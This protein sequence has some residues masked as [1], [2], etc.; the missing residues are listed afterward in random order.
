[1]YPHLHCCS[2]RVLE[3][4]LPFLRVVL[5]KIDTADIFVTEFSQTY[6]SKY[7]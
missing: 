5:M 4:E 7:I 3:I 1:M 2:Q 6:E